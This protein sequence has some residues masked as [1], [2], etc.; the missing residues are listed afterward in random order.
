M[1]P[2]SG[3]QKKPRLIELAVASVT[4]QDKAE[5]CVYVING[6]YGISG[7]SA[8]YI[9]EIMY[10]VFALLYF[11]AVCSGGLCPYPSGLLHWHWGNHM[12]APVPVK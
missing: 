1:Y 8:K 7:C 2:V 4:K 11:A 9:S 12:I 3:Y 6:K 5:K 10:M